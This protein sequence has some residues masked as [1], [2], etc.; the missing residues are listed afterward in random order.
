MSPDSHGMVVGI[1]KEET[2]AGDAIEELKSIGF[3][4][5]Q[6]SFAP[7]KD[8]SEMYRIRDTL[9][10]IGICQEEVDYYTSE[11]E[12]GRSVLLIRH[13]GRRIEA[14][15][16]LF[17]NGTRSHKYLDVGSNSTN[18]STSAKAVVIEQDD[19]EIESL[20]KLLKRAGLDHLL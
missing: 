5:D 7:R 2:R 11:F 6:I 18:A 17:L 15:N 13:E 4:D 10:H 12:S 1:F 9:E 3:R 16:I 19:D 20:H 8:N 14:L